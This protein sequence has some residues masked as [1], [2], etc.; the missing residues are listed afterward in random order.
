MK[1]RLVLVLLV[2]A[3]LGIVF[4]L[5]QRQASDMNDLTALPPT[6]F[7]VT[8]VVSVALPTSDPSASNRL[9]VHFIDVGQGDSILIRTPTRHTALIDGGGENGLALDYLRS[10]GV[11]KL[12]SVIV[13]HP[14]ADHI[15]G[16]V[17]ILNAV[18]VGGIWTS[19]AS[20]T[21]YVYER[22]LDTIA[23]RA[24][25]YYEVETSQTIPVG[26]L[27]F[28]VLHSSRRE[29]NL[30]DTSLVLHLNYGTVSF[31]FTGDAEAPVENRLS[32]TIPIQLRSTV[33]KVGHHGS[34]TSSTLG[35]LK[36]VQ[37]VVAV[38]SARQNN[39]YGHPHMSTLENLA[40]VG[41]VVYGTD[42][43]G[44]VMVS[45]DGT[46]LHVTTTRSAAPTQIE[47]VRQVEAAP[48]IFAT[49][50]GTTE[51]AFD[52]FGGDRDCGHFDTHAEA[53]AFFIAAGGPDRDPHRLDGD[54]DG[55]A[56]ESLP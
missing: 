53:Q 8:P 40:A 37:P 19:G 24:V 52:P 55:T 23:D 12:D 28:D 31:L 25:P 18:P 35:F 29:S 4:W 20:H 39:Q 6:Y 44:S 16:L 22:L 26:E 2:I 42:V 49:A 11:T 34:Y 10:L 43:H 15:G 13:S 50:S 14:H 51:F 9:E 1:R 32:S 17:Q 5:S 48:T 54:N 46:S 41:A 47:T 30:N 56:C 36:A 21:T 38:Y 7:Q 3:G 27:T 33:L 45:T